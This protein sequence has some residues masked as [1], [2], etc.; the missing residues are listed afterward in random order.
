MYNENEN[1]VGLLHIYKTCPYA[2]EISLYASLTMYS[3]NISL[4][5]G[6]SIVIS[7]SLSLALSRYIHCLGV[8]SYQHRVKEVDVCHHCSNVSYYRSP[9]SSICFPLMTNKDMD[10][11]LNAFSNMNKIFIVASDEEF[12]TLGKWS[13]KA[14]KNM[15]SQTYNARAFD[16]SSTY[17]NALA[18]FVRFAQWQRVA[19]ITHAS[20]HVYVHTVEQF[21]QI[22]SSLVTAEVFQV[23]EFEESVDQVFKRIQGIGYR[24]II[25]ALPRRNLNQVLCKRLAVKMV[26]PEYAWLVVVGGYE[27]EITLSLKCKRGIITF[28]LEEFWVA[29]VSR[30]VGKSPHGRIGTGFSNTSGTGHFCNH[31]LKV[32]AVV[33]YQWGEH[34]VHIANYSAENGLGKVSFGHIPYDVP[35]V[36]SGVGFVIFLLVQ[37]FIFV[38]LTVA[39]VLYIAHRHQPTVKSSSVSLSVLIFI[40]CYM[41]LLYSFIINLTVLPGYRKA[42]TRAKDV[43]CVLR[44]WTHALSVPTVTILVVIL[45]KLV[46]IYKLFKNQVVLKKWKCHNLTLAVYVLILIFPIVILCAAQSLT[47]YK[48][49]VII[50][51]GEYYLDCRGNVLEYLLIIQLAYILVLCSLV[52]LMAIKTRNVEFE[53]FKGTRKMIILMFAVIGIVSL[54]PANYIVLKS[55]RNQFLYTIA[56][57]QMTS[58]YLVLTVVIFQFIPKFQFLFIKYVAR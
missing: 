3:S 43:F 23:D 2:V 56:F 26:W 25:V 10:A 7:A 33:I 21:Y 29:T 31:R 1:N 4:L 24:I 50:S 41:L 30:F 32:N 14:E 17:A 15:S 54:G 18:E 40:S 51:N 36:S 57:S 20:S 5:F 49:T 45:L 53:D 6:V 47:Q 28:Q 52:I 42:S 34:P 55:T 16:S 9:N 12:L 8:L 58:A 37:L 38:A 11:F 13:Y 44:L 46:R 48:S 22:V 27:E 35:V 39:L 19:V